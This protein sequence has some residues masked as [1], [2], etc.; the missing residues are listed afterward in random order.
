MRQLCPGN[1]SIIEKAGEDRT[2]QHKP[3][4][5]TILDPEV[6]AEDAKMAADLEGRPS[7]LRLWQSQ[8]GVCP[9][10]QQRIT[11]QTGWE[12]HHITA[13]VHG[14]SDTMENRVLLHPTCHKQVH[15]LGLTVL[16]PRPTKGR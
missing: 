4:K 8:N 10:C 3:I 11:R 15:S 2:S 1:Q 9:V 16:K 13:R 14:G 7:L 12:N 6:V 5:A